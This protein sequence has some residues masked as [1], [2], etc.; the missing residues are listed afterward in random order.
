MANIYVLNQALVADWSG[1]CVFPNVDQLGYR[2]VEGHGA[3][4][5][6]RFDGFEFAQ[7]DNPNVIHTYKSD[8]YLRFEKLFQDGT[9]K[10]DDKFVLGIAAPALS[11]LDDIWVRQNNTIEGL[12][13]KITVYDH[14]LAPVEDEGIV[15]DFSNK[16]EDGRWLVDPVKKFRYNNVGTAAYASENKVF[17]LVA[18]VV[19]LP[20]PDAWFTDCV[21][22]C[23]PNI[24]VR[25]HYLPA[26]LTADLIECAPKDVYDAWID[27]FEAL[28]DT[29]ILWDDIKV[30]KSSGG[31]KK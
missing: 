11:E 8:D 5:A 10:V 16:I 19:A 21:D 7:T 12:Q 24:S 17:W 13:L 25:T 26:C 29:I 4:K 27:A 31:F 20:E 23:I 14:L 3:R 2:D 18:E 15:I 30:R 1:E 28:T 6:Y 9:L 22:S